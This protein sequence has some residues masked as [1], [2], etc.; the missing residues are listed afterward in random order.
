MWDK[1]ATGNSTRVDMRM[2]LPHA[3]FLQLLDEKEENHLLPQGGATS[4][5]NDA[6]AVLHR[7]EEL[8]FDIGYPQR[9]ERPCKI[10]LRMTRGPTNAC[11]DFHVDGNYAT[12][13]SRCRWH[14]M[15]RAS[16]KEVACASSSEKGRNK[17]MSW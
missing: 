3:A 2:T 4:S 15:T 12:G 16:T 14:L 10:A 9:L 1:T 5:H 13:Q 8:F 6:A 17:M 7:L 11:I